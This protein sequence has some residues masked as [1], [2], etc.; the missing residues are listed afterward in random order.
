MKL[1]LIEDSALTE[2]E[3]II[4][5]QA[6]DAGI[7][8]M[9]AMLRAF[10][11]KLTGL[12]GGETYV[13]DEKELLYADTA[14]RRTFLYTCDGVYETPL[15]LYELEAQLPADFF[16]SGKSSLLNFE[17]I[18]SI[19]PDIGGRLLVTMSNGEKQMVS[20]Q[21]AQEVRRRLGIK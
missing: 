11:H 7:L 1:R 20:R 10:D 6:A 15:R 14:D 16:R 2:T 18:R 3:I 5:C 9:A 21:Y 17:H 13:L 8:K 19:R 12:R 4:R